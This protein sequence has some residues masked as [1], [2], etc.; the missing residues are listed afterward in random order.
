[1]PE[2][3]SPRVSATPRVSVVVPDFQ[4]AAYLAATLDS[5]LAQAFDDYELVVADH[6][7]DDGTAAVIERYRHRPKVRVLAPTSP[8]GGARANWNRVSAE[9]RG[10]LVMLV[11]G[12]DLIAPDALGEQVRAMDANPGAVLVASPRDLI[13]SR[14]RVVL[15]GR[16]L[17]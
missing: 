6:A 5:I 17:A 4:N 16:G 3:A 7:S 14:G 8:G 2:P 13:D 1:M 10:E 12:D 9:A 11:C 15:R